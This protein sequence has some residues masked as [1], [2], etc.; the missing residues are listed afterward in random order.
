MRISRLLLL[1]LSPLLLLLVGSAA[2]IYFDLGTWLNLER[3]YT[4]R[5]MLQ[6]WITAAGIFAPLVYALIYALCTAFSIP[7]AVILTIAAGFLF[8]VLVSTVTVVIGATLGATLIFLAVRFGLGDT[9]MRKAGPRI[10]K[11]Q[12]GFQQDA[13]NYLLILRLIPL[14]P[15]WLVNIAAAMIGVPL[16][17][18]FFAT[19]IGIIP[20]TFVY[21]LLGNGIGALLEAGQEPNLGIIF[22]PGIL[23]PI[24]GLAAL[25]LLQVIY[26]RFRRNKIV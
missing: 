23:A 22:Q 15:F 18:Y 25:S 12:Q 21:C 6:Q 4:N 9:L 20:G 16:G 17:T 3:I 19:L 7:G 10:Q 11:L 8:G 26:K 1:R 14:F 24:L 5:Q 13:L 2:F